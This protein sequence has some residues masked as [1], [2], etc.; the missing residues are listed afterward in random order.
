MAQCCLL[1]LTLLVVLV[2]CD[3]AN[4]HVMLMSSSSD[5]LNSSG[6]VDVARMAITRVN[7]V[8]SLLPGHQLVLS[9]SKDTNVRINCT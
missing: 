1:L 5:R 3:A 7:S 9:E 2:L 8:P 6:A 4:L